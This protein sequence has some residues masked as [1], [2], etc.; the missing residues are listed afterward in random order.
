M[1]SP[2][3][4]MPASAA[5][6]IPS[7]RQWNDAFVPCGWYIAYS[8]SW[9][10]SWYSVIPHAPP[11]DQLGVRVGRLGGD[12]DRRGVASGKLVRGQ[13]E[14]V[15][16]TTVLRGEPSEPLVE[17]PAPPRF[18]LGGQAPPPVRGSI[19]LAGQQL[20]GPFQKR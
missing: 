13:I 11:R 2:K 20:A 18:Q 6:S 15:G 19:F 9:Y 7:S 12:L 5:R 8:A 3:P 16:Q 10:V 4:A 14:G 1:P 17:M